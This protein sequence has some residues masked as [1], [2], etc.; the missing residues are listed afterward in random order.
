MAHEIGHN[1]G[2]YH[3]FDKYH[4]GKKNSCN[5]G[6]SGNHVMS[7]GELQ[8]MKKWS[9]CSKKDFEAHFLWVKSKSYLTWCMEG[10]Y[11]GLDIF[12]I[13]TNM[14]LIIIYIYLADIGNVCGAGGNSPS[15]PPPSACTGT[16]KI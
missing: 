13:F 2:M 12:L 9:T 11:I 3:D 1:L 6:N 16:C 10:I 8:A 4:G 14:I 5:S 7:Y 15:P